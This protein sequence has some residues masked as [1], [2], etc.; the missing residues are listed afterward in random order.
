M[1]GSDII[2]RAKARLAVVVAERAIALNSILEFIC[3]WDY[4]PPPLLIHCVRTS[5]ALYDIVSY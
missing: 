5:A 4:A 1:G 3:D 2:G